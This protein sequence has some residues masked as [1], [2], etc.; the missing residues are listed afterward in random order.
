MD[1]NNNIPFL[2][3]HGLE[4]LVSQNPGV[5]DKYMGTTELVKSSFHDGIAIF[6]R[7]YGGC[8]LPSS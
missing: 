4:R 8:R 2:L 3:R 1:R 5:R 7:A 6:S